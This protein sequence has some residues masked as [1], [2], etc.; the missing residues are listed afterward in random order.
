M[1]LRGTWVLIQF[2]SLG[3]VFSGSPGVGA[4]GIYALSIWEKEAV[5]IIM[6]GLVCAFCIWQLRVPESF[7]ASR[8]FRVGGW[9][10]QILWFLS[11]SSLLFW[12]V[13]FSPF[14]WASPVV[15]W[16]CFEVAFCMWV[17][18]SPLGKSWCLGVIFS[19][20]SAVLFARVW[21][22]SWDAEGQ[23]ILCFLEPRVMHQDAFW[24][25][26]ALMSDDLNGGVWASH[27]EL[28][29]AMSIA[30]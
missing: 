18:F 20:M 16:Y 30:A 26:C 6:C 10:M 2:P 14:L 3:L 13:F 17:L 9:E 27:T 7:I 15:E 12:T 1:R 28:Y 21:C 22:A 24:L 19:C 11:K 25:I 4:G 23:W 8:K 29:P 5:V